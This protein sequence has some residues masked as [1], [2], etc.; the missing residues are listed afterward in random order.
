[1]NKASLSVLI[2]ASLLVLGG[3]DKAKEAAS[4]ATE[5]AKDA[6]NSA[7]DVTKDV[8][9]GATDAAKGVAG[10]AGDVVSGA[11]DVT[12]D[13]AAGAT[14]AAKGVAGK[15]GDV[16][17]GAV[18]ATKDVAV[19][20]TDAAKGVA[21]KAGDAVSGAVDT[22]KDAA[23]AILEVDDAGNAVKDAVTGG[24]AADALKDKV[25]DAT[26]ATE[27]DYKETLAA[28]TA[29]TKQAGSSGYQW[30]NTSKLI[31]AAKK[32]AAKGDFAK[33]NTLAAEAK[34]QSEAA[35]KQAKA[36]KSAA[37]RFQ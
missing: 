32:A 13:V 29:L 31:K 20:A 33:A 37:P 21:G 30:S 1:M 4:A 16:V 7:V 10:K 25:S 24:G 35:L 19:G 6:A 12:K 23:A 17:S 15:V 14:D 36:G 28:A 27:S 26:G 3:C 22:T 8:A 2:I 18:D 34:A 11:V 5:T 9:A